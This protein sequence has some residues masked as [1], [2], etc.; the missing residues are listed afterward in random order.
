MQ[1][2]TMPASARKPFFIASANVPTPK[3]RPLAD[4]TPSAKPT[5][6]VGEG[7]VGD[8]GAPSVLSRAHA[9]AIQIGAF[10]DTTQARSQLEAYAKKSIDVLGQ[11]AQ[12]I[13]PFKDLEGHTLY[14]AR[15]GPFIER[16]ARQVCSRLSQRGQTCFAV[17]ASS[18]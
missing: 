3:P 7:D 14:R 15:F 2:V 13:V 12:M 5:S 9:W 18:R 6:D 1:T 10:A 11:A 16:D 17:L 8:I 4:V